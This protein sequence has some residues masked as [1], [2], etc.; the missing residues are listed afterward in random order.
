[1]NPLD[2][3]V[4]PYA[5][6]LCVA[7]FI[8]LAWRH[9]AGLCFSTATIR[10]IA[11]VEVGGVNYARLLVGMQA[12]AFCLLFWRTLTGPGQKRLL[13]FFSTRYSAPLWVLAVLW[14][15]V[16]ADIVVGGS[17]EFARE[18]LK[19]S[20]S[21]VI[22]P[23]A[24]V[25]L[26][27][28]C[29]GV[30]Q[31]IRGYIWG[32]LLFSA[33]FLLPT[34]IP[35]WQEQ[36]IQES[37]FGGTRLIIY[38]LD[39]ISSGHYFMLG[40]LGLLGVIMLESRRQIVTQLGWAG[41]GALTMLLYLNGTRQLLLALVLAGFMCLYTYFR[42]KSGLAVLIIGFLAISSYV[43]WDY[44]RQAEVRERFTAEAVAHEIE[45]SRGEIWKEAMR[46]SLAHPITGSG[47]KR[48]GEITSRYNEN[49]GSVES[50]LDGAH[51]FY[52]DIFAE[53]GLILGGVALIAF[54]YCILVIVRQ[55]NPAGRLDLWVFGVFYLAL[56]PTY[57]FSGA[58]ADTP[59]PYLLSAGMLGFY[60]VH[61]ET[62][63]MWAMGWG[64]A[65]QPRR[66]AAPTG[67]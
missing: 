13:H 27:L 61:H 45:S 11:W 16:I 65:K 51:G 53:H 39:T 67:Q 34:V 14:L 8:Y 62:M 9:P 35:I 42:N 22:F 36:R 4:A 31:S 12:I 25:L 64:L 17:N 44:L 37:L 20:L 38:G 47:F 19:L 40:A 3:N 28:A 57:V 30:T 60:L 43:L 58:L 15:K 49:T 32:M 56:V 48:Y 23:T 26:S 54:V 66:R 46:Y 7:V 1:M 6:Y 59:G 41:V 52:Q 10:G 21:Q 5:V 33:A 63:P 18:A 50:Q 29:Y 24:F 55:I 2:N